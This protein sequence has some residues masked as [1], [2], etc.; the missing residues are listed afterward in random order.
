MLTLSQAVSVPSFISHSYCILKIFKDF[1]VPVI[2][3]GINE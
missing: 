2:T 3:H 1:E